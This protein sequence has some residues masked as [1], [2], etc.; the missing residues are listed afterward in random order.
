M[1][2]VRVSLLR[3]LAVATALMLSI[4]S[5]N[6]AKPAGD[7]ETVVGFRFEVR[8]VLAKNCFSCHGPDEGHREAEL[9]LDLR[10][11]AIDLGAIVPGDVEESELIARIMGLEP[12]RVSYL[13][14]AAGRFGPIDEPSIEQRGEAWQELVS[15][16]HILDEPHLRQLRA[17]PA[18]PL[19][20]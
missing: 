5:G 19:V 15:P 12:S 14:L 1:S 10:D 18:G 4:V 11:S 16:F 9:R 20:S 17:T 6:P 3:C 8:P 13:S 2:N 7:Q